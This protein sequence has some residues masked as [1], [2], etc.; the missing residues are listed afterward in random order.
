MKQ[1]PKMKKGDIVILSIP[2][3]PQQS[4][5]KLEALITEREAMVALNQYRLARDETMAYG[6]ESFMDLAKRIDSERERL[7]W[8]GEK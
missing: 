6:E 3:A 7:I 5:L 1:I 8:L 2:N 4:M